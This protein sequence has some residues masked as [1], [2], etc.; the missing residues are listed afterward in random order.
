MSETVG[1]G[2][3][4]ALARLPWD[5]VRLTPVE[6][7]DLDLFH[8]WQND[9]GLRD[10]TMGYRFPIPRDR[11]REWIR[12][13]AP[14]GHPSRVVY[15][16]RCD[17]ALVGSAQLQDIH[18]LHRT[19]GL[20]VTVAAEGAGVLGVGHVASVLV[21]DFAFRGLDL[22]R[23]EAECLDVNRPTLR[24]LEHLGFRHEGTRR[25]AHYVGG[26]AHDTHVYGLLRAELAVRPPETAHRLC[27]TFPEA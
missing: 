13:L 22:R 9:A 27:R 14:Q 8:R 6:E 15:A 20:G 25:Q 16:I 2:R 18:P 23:V 11:V 7:E 5:R 24:A 10:M 4:R 19:A 1:P 12:G 17:G 21:L 26:T 3:R